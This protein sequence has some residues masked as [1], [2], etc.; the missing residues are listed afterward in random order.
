MTET[1]KMSETPKSSGSHEVAKFAKKT[2]GYAKHSN[3]LFG[4]I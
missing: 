1:E 4:E 3:H 2:D